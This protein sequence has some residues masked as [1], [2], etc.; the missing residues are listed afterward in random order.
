MEVVELARRA[1]DITVV[2]ELLQSAEELL[3][4]FAEQRGDVIG[5]K[6]TMA[7]EQTQ[8]LRVTRSEFHLR[9]FFRPAKTWMSEE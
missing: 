6:K 4:A 8:N 3:S 5:A 9:K 2:V 7:T 1:F